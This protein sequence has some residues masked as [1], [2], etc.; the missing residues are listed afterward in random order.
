MLVKRTLTLLCLLTVV[1]TMTGC[2]TPTPYKVSSQ[3][4][5]ITLYYQKQQASEDLP[6]LVSEDNSRWYGRDIGSN[7]YKYTLNKSVS[8]QCFKLMPKDDPYGKPIHRCIKN[9]LPNQ[10][11]KLIAE[12]SEIEQKIAHYQKQ[13]P[14]DIQS[15][16]RSLNRNPA[17]QNNRCTLIAAQSTPQRPRTIC[18]DPDALQKA[19]IS[20]LAPLGSKACKYALQEERKRNG[21]RASNAELFL[22]GNACSSMLSQR[23]SGGEIG[24]G[25]AESAADAIGDGE[26]GFWDGLSSLISSVAMATRVASAYSCFDGLVPN[27]EGKI[28]RWKEQVRTIQQKPYKLR[29]QCKYVAKRL[30]ESQQKF[31]HVKASIRKLEKQL[32]NNRKQRAELEQDSILLV[33]KSTDSL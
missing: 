20:C 33:L 2:S 1:L 26:G 32:D 18:D 14:S 23:L 30:S 28:E 11:A 10:H 21:K 12:K 31:A 7:R 25:L 8:G 22:A 29:D 15:L 9:P 17:Y 19:Q 13:Y 3:Y 4:D 24:L 6:T 27:C 5:S 16:L